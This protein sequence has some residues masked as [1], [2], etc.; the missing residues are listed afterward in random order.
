MS[1]TSFIE[2]QKEIQRN[3][4]EFI[5]NAAEDQDILKQ[6][7]KYELSEDQKDLK[8]ILYFIV[9]ICNN[10]QRSSSFF[11][12]IEQILQFYKTKIIQNFNNSEIFHIFRQNKRLLLYLYEEKIFSLD[13]DIMETM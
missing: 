2:K 11:S 3:I 8:I 12:K 4:L 1:I 10:H 5:D 9:N 7:E 6:L 13:Q